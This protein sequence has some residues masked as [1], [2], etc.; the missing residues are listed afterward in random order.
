MGK[1]SRNGLVKL[2]FNQETIVDLSPNRRLEEINLKEVFEID[3][4]TFS[5]IENLDYELLIV[6]E[7][8]FFIYL[9]FKFTN[10]ALVSRSNKADQMSIKIL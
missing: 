10:P 3:L 6:E 9:K 5:G 8:P 2:R 1:F 7:S 4:K